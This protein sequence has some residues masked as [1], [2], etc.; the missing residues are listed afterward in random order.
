[1]RS[2]YHSFLTVFLG[3]SVSAKASDEPSSE[4]GRLSRIKPRAILAL[5]G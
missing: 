5:A 4:H 3:Q 2:S 1:V